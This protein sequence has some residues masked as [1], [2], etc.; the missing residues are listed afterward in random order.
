LCPDLKVTITN[1][2]FIKNQVFCMSSQ[3]IVGVGDT[4]DK[5]FVGVI[6]TGEQLRGSL[7]M[8]CKSASLAYVIYVDCRAVRVSVSKF[9]I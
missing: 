4:G 8:V 2:Y 3:M 1:Y 5:F 6:D 9:H 7:I